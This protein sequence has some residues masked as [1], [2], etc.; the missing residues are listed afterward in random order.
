MVVFGVLLGVVSRYGKWRAREGGRES[1]PLVGNGDGWDATMVVRACGV[2]ALCV[3]VRSEN[4]SHWLSIRARGGTF[5]CG[6][7]IPRTMPECIVTS[8][9][10]GKARRGRT[11][12]EK[13]VCDRRAAGLGKESGEGVFPLRGR[14]SLQL[15]V[16]KPS[17]GIRDFCFHHRRCV[18]GSTEGREKA[19]VRE[20]TP[21]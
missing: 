3:L 21:P 12:R 4:C 20:R 14:L 6:T 18:R 19:C 9:E 15:K 17:Q 16:K 8:S 10:G 2:R 5:P 1:G 11:R 7:C 13:E